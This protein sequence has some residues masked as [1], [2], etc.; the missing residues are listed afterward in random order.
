MKSI[1]S[2]ILVCA[3]L[4]YAPLL[5]AAET[6]PATGTVAETMTSGG[7]VYI[8]LEE[9]GI[10]IAANAFTVS[11][12]NKIQ[13]SGGMEMN[14]F[15]SK[16]LDRTFESILF[17]SNA[18]L[19][20]GESGANHAETMAGHESKS[21]P[22]QKPVSAQAPAPGEIKPL[23]AGKTVAAIFAESADLK[24]KV[25][26]LNAR[27]IKINKAIMGRN[28]I[29]LQDGTGTEP[30]NKLLATS[31]EVV[32]VGDVVIAKGTVVT[33]MDLGYGYKYK[34]LLE[35]ASFSPGVK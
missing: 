12:G 1:R 13:Y 5:T 22:L 29:T 7:Y 33:D 9:Q 18:S 34:V 15:H 10:W 4:M 26:S 24:E 14:D 8:K 28:W 11:K 17:V 6:G 19:V 2:I 16:S 27:V 30:D 3:F 31:Q 25:V 32:S 23:Q 21:E 35:E 20:G